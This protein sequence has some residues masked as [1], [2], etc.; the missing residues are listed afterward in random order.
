MVFIPIAC[1]VGTVLVAALLTRA[2]G[3]EDQ[4]EE[5]RHVRPGRRIDVHRPAH[6]VIPPGQQ[7]RRVEVAGIVHREFVRH[8]IS[9]HPADRRP[10]IRGRGRC[11]HPRP[12]I[13]RRRHASQGRAAASKPWRRRKGVARMAAHPPE[14]KSQIISTVCSSKQQRH[15]LHRARYD[16]TQKLKHALPELEIFGHGVR[17]IDRKNEALDDFRYHVAIENH[18]HPHHWT[19]KLADSFLGLCLPFYHG[20]PNTA[21]YFPQESYI[22][23]D[24]G[25]FDESLDRIRKAIANDEY[26]RRLPAIRE[27]RRLVL[28][29]YST[30]PQLARLITERNTGHAPKNEPGARL[31][32]RHNI[33]ASSPRQAIAMVTEK[34]ATRLRHT[35]H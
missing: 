15:T 4:G 33:R 22:S 17:P 18:I 35:F 1:L 6:P 11:G 3:K 32:S 14:D 7:Q 2:S 21:E 27:A 5:R 28:E 16:F 26:T 19:E 31:L 25:R 23:I 30:F 9:D 8:G 20:C 29:E 34:L 10:A 12:M 24:I 13:G